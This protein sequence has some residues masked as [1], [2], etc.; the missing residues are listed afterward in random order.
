MCTSG[1]LKLQPGEQGERSNN[2]PPPNPGSKM[3]PQ[4]HGMGPALYILVIS[5]TSK[6][7]TSSRQ[8]RASGMSPGIRKESK[9]QS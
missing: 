9:A 1:S 3:N 4:I 2:A 5:T 7:R 6:A 8:S